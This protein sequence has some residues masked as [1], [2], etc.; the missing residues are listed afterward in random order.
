MSLI[1]IHISDISTIELNVSKGIN[2]FQFFVSPMTNY[3]EP[4]YEKAFAFAKKNNIYFFVHASYSINLSKR[5]TDS[6]WWVQQ[7]INEIQICGEINTRGIVIHTGKQMDL[8]KAEAINNMYTL[9]LHIHSKTLKQQ[10][11]RILLETPS[12]QGSETLTQIFDFCKFMNKFYDHPDKKIGERF[13]ICV[14]TCHIFAAGHDIRSKEDMN[15]FFGT[16]D[17]MIGIN[18]IKLCHLNDS[19]NDLGSKIDRHA[20]IG[21]GKIGA[22]AIIRIVNFMKELQIP[23]IFETPGNLIYT[24]YQMIT[25]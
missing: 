6:D 17:K 12:G 15:I 4:M 23:I 3:R 2:L 21:H 10:N 5:W 7:F 11:V 1:G 18:K 8:S 19:K 13:G 24:D 22:E 9:L 16:I 25:D 14:D 20:N